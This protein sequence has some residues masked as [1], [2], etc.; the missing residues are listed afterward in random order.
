MTYPTQHQIRIIAGSC[1][2]WHG[3]SPDS[4]PHEFRDDLIPMWKTARDMCRT[5]GVEPILFSDLCEMLTGET[6]LA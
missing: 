6:S 4:E 5:F 3:W 1:M 2:H